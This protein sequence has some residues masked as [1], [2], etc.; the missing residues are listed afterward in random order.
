MT[1]G[2]S[3][4][5]LRA[6]DAAVLARALQVI[7]PVRAP[8]SRGPPLDHLAALLAGT[9]NYV[10][11]ACQGDTPVGY[12]CAYRFPRV[13]PSGTLV[14]LYDLEVAPDHRRRG[15]GRGLVE[16]LLQ[17]C[18]ADGVAMVWAG[19]GIDNDAA[20]QTFEAVGGRRVSETYV[21][22]EFPLSDG[23]G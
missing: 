1:D 17:A 6:G 12:L 20:R 14:Y 3:T 8:D 21:E 5:R 15:V 16:S 10:F 7:L 19:T 2:L 18:R 13:Y 4:V 9:G 11:L 23:D 22:Y